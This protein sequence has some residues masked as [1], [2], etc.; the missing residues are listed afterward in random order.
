MSAVI[1]I[2]N[3]RKEF[4]DLVAV[5]GLDLAIPQGEINGL[6]GPNGA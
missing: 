6:I 2:T 4:D 1:S 3:L 5:Q